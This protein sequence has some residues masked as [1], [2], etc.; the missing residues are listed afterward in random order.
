MVI[1]QCTDDLIEFLNALLEVDRV[2]LSELMD[3]RPRCSEAM[4]DHP[5]IQV[6]SGQSG[7]VYAGVLGL[8]N[9]FCGTID[10]GSHAGYGPITARYA[11]DNV[12]I[13]KFVRTESCAGIE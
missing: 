5:A 9:G 4:A 1:R 8:L 6:I 11:E 13:E 7:A 12:T 10:C 2:W 3:L